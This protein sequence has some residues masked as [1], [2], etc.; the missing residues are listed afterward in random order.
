MIPLNIHSLQPHRCLENPFYGKCHTSDNSSTT[1]TEESI[2]PVEQAT[3]LHEIL[4][5]I[6]QLRKELQ[7]LKHAHQ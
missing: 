2:K 7:E 1:T 4:Y 3:M 5:E 6:G